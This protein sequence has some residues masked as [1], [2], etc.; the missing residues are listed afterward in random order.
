MT[1]FRVLIL[2]TAMFFVVLAAIKFAG[3]HPGGDIYLLAAFGFGIVY[4]IIREK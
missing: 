4:L 1:F 3:P 2:L